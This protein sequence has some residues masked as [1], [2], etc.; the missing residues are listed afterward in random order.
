MD[1]LRFSLATTVARAKLPKVFV[2]QLLWREEFI[3]W[4]DPLQGSLWIPPGQNTPIRSQIYPG[5]L[6]KLTTFQTVFTVDA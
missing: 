3:F 1:R 4:D 5:S 2:A 6:L